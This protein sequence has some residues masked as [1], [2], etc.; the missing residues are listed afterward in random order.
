MTPSAEPT[1]KTATALQHAR[2][3][4]L[5]GSTAMR[6]LALCGVVGAFGTAT[7]AGAQVLPTGGS[8]SAGAAT[9]SSGGSTLTVNQASQN[10][11]INWQTF[12]IGADQSVVF[13]QPNAGAVA[14]NRVVGADPSAI[15]GRLTA[16]GQVFLVN[17]NGVL[18][19]QGSQVS[20]GGL[21]ASTL[22]IADADFMAG[23]YGFSGAGGA[24][25]NQGAITADGGYVALLGGQVS[26]E[27]V[28]QAKLGTVALAAGEAMTLDLA[29]EG[30]LNITI[31]RGA[32][33]ALTANG[34][35][36][37]ADGGRVL[38]SARTAG[39]L[40]RTVVN[41]TGVVEARTLQNRNGVISLSGD[42]AAGDVTVGGVL[43]V[44]GSAPGQ[45]GGAVVVT[46][47]QIGLIDARIDASGDAG[48]G[49]VLVGGDFQGGGDTPRA[50]AVYMSGGSAVSADAT[51]LGDG[52][53]VVLWSDGSTRARGDI[54]ARGGAEGGSGGLIETSGHWL[55]VSGVRVNAGA[56]LGANG[57][58]LLDPADVIIGAGTSNGS[59]IAGV[60]TPDSGVGSATVDAAALQAALNGGANIT[61]TTV[62]AGVSGAGL[63]DITVN[64]SL[65]WTTGRTLTLLAD[66]DIIVAGGAAITASAQDAQIVMTAGHDVRIG[67]AL[68]ASEQNTRITLTAGNDIRATA[69]LTATGLN[70][71]ID[72]NAGNDISLVA[73]TADGGGAGP[74]VNLRAD[75]NITLNGALSAAGGGVLLRADAD[76]SGPGALAGTVIFAGPGAVAAS[77][78]TGIRFNPDGYA[79]TA[80]EIAA[81]DLKV[82]GAMD[83]RAW[84]FVVG[85]NR[86]YDGTTAATLQFR[87]PAPADNPNVGNIVT[88]NAG[89]ATFATKDV[90]TPKTINFSGYTLGGADLAR[91]ELFTTGVTTA[92]ITPIPLLITANDHA[93][94][95]YGDSVSLGSQAFTTSGLVLVETVGSVSLVSAGAAP[96]ATVASYAIV[97]SG[98]VANGAF[99]PTN[100]TITYVNGAL[101]VV[102]APLTVTANSSTKAYGDSLT[103]TGSEFSST[104]LRNGD[105][106]AGITLIS[107]GGAANATSGPYAIVASTAVGGSY[108][109][110]NYITTYVDG[111]LT[112]AAAP[113][114]P[115]VVTP[116]VVTPPVVTPPVPPVVT[117]PSTPPVVAPPET[118]PVV[119]QPTPT[120]TATTLPQLV[121]AATRPTLTPSVTTTPETSDGVGTPTALDATSSEGGSQPD[122]RVTLLEGSSLVIAGGGLRMPA[123][124]QLA[125]SSVRPAGPAPARDASTI[126]APGPTPY[127]PP[128]QDRN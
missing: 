28:I 46:G 104:G 20:V 100:Y 128:K 81:Y 44:S 53:K 48:G 75:Q 78:T 87:N 71:L 11:A 103:F 73:L 63:G 36:L 21:V 13:A 124:S 117:P 2:K 18:F 91:F 5:A 99:L 90:G 94:K 14:L 101:P 60:F 4:A 93:P 50:A 106:I 119:G 115:P 92:N 34:G 33:E 120:D 58:W 31:D 30:L 95:I 42:V 79:N 27:G 40:I 57:E 112:V 16:N 65:T 122:V 29:G 84:A 127:Y 125:D 32:V 9:I 22:D 116:P 35:L 1:P 47:R 54:S 38:M 107:Y 15:L 61:I 82:T 118:A 83:A 74:S 114:P 109:P 8:V 98:A 25:L 62:N 41:N 77:A 7:A 24:V 52:G 105:S 72:M 96:G 85:V 12:N 89:T 113:A 43:D 17:P 111:V 97:P 39:D 49:V 6:L 26:N 88:L 23:R 110:A 69:A 86:P 70:A 126:P 66:H 3:T 121:L 67:A 102:G 59:I 55:D 45:T 123:Q 37:N 68:T 64:S 51:R 19:G 108:S 76:G 56:P 10:A 80:T